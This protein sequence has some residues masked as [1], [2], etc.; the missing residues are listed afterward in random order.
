MNSHLQTQKCPYCD[1]EIPLGGY[2]VYCGNVLP[3]YKRCSKCNVIILSNVLR[4]PSCDSNAVLFY[5]ND[6]SQI[7]PTLKTT[8]I[9]FRPAILVIFLLASYSMVQLTIGFVVYFFFPNELDIENNALS[10]LSFLFILI[11]SN[12]LMIGLITRIFSFSFEEKT[13]AESLNKFWLV[14]ILVTAIS[15]IDI[16]TSI[17]DLFFD[18]VGISSSQ[19][20]PYDQFFGDPVGIIVF[21]LLAAFVGPIFEELV[22]R[23]Y[24]ISA[25]SNLTNSKMLLI[26]FSALIF[27]FSHVSSDLLNGSLR[28][29]LLHFCATSILGIILGIVYILWG[30]RGAIIF[31]SSWNIFSLLIQ[32]LVD[33]GLIALVE[34]LIMLFTGFTFISVIFL[35]FHFRAHLR[36]LLYK[37]T[38]FSANEF[39]L[40][41]SNFILTI[42]YALS[43]ALLGILLGQNLVTIGINLILNIIGILFG[44]MLLN[45]E[46][47]SI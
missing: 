33:N 43:P 7:F 30:L 42:V 39:M 44:I 45:K 36:K 26:C 25:M 8:M 21:A 19:T 17:I 3:K 20:S 11:M 23:R 2:C 12:V 18:L 32:L 31:H 41:F 4:C 13:N 34:L 35:F 5:R 9:K 24:A 14:I 40:I 1:K 37:I 27:A 29:A 22:Y 28:Y 10:S 47:P 15:F 6:E 16:F 46:N 38:P